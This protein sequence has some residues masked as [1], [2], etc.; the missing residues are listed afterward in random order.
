MANKS[1]ENYSLN[2]EPN[3]IKYVII[4]NES[5]IEEFL[6][7]FQKYK[8]RNHLYADIQRLSTRLLTSEQIRYDF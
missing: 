5:E 6:E 7:I 3:D 4:D 1:I 2:F 8:G